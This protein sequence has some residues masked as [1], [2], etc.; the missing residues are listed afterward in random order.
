MHRVSNLLTFCT[1][2]AIK[3]NKM[4]CVCWC[5]LQRLCASRYSVFLFVYT[6]TDELCKC[7]QNN[8][9]VVELN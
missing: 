8:R 2:C 5:S 3:V 4:N 7:K 6:I 1:L 9:N